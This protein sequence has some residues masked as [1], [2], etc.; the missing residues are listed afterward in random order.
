MNRRPGRTIFVLAGSF[1]HQEADMAE[2][3][4]QDSE[5][6]TG[7]YGGDDGA[8]ENE[9]ALIAPGEDPGAVALTEEEESQQGK[10]QAERKEEK[11]LR[12]GEEHPA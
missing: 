12:T 6:R 2:Q 8:L 5:D 4:Q 10:T 1:V 7:K 3:Q 11:D 9:Q